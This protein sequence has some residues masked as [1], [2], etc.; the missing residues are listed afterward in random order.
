M[1]TKQLDREKKAFDE[2]GYSEIYDLANQN[3]VK[4]LST[5]LKKEY[6]I[7]SKLLPER[8]LRRIFFLNRHLSLSEMQT[9][10]RDKNL[11]STLKK[12]CAPQLVIW[13]TNAIRKG[14]GSPDIDWH[15]DK[16][17]Q[18]GDEQLIN[19]DDIS[20]HFSVIIALDDITINN[21]ALQVLPK[22]HKP[23][24]GFE[25]DLRVMKDRPISEHYSPE[26]PNQYQSSV[27]TIYLKRGQFFVFHSAMYHKSNAYISGNT[28]I[29]LTMR[30]MRADL[31]YPENRW[32][33]L[34]SHQLVHI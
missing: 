15:H 6:T 1:L 20:S 11:T 5:K 28:R 17:F 10:I 2:R 22:S 30:L 23:L 13:R 24:E 27:E 12:L 8:V 16:H 34:K 14:L 25:R 9:V 7:W 3:V 29:A 31:S 19:L 18:D 32:T 21:G 33:K 4:K 26:L